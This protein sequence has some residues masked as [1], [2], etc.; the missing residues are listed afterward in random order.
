MRLIKTQNLKH[1]RWAKKIILYL[2]LGH[3]QIPMPCSLLLS[4]TLR[5]QG[6]SIV[7]I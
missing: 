4:R 1:K 2:G 6:K 5:V 7:L 3:R